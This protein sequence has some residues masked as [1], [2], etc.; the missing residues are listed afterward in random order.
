MS[1]FDLNFYL[2]MALEDVADFRYEK[3]VHQL[4]MK[5][6]W[7]LMRVFFGKERFYIKHHASGC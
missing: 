3:I 4:V 2:F 5:S 6:F 1:N 7:C